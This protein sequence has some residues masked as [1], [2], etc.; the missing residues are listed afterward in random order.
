MKK[1]CS[2]F[3]RSETFKDKQKMLERAGEAFLRKIFWDCV[4]SSG[5]LNHGEHAVSSC[6]CCIKKCDDMN[7]ICPS[8]GEMRGLKRTYSRPLKN[9]PK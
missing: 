3:P 9:S 5:T 1:L 8:S 2:L 7:E 6:R 4:I